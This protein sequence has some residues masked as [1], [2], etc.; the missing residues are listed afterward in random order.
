MVVEKRFL[1]PCLERTSV[2]VSTQWFGSDHLPRAA[3]FASE[4]SLSGYTSFISE[5]VHQAP[6]RAA[7]LDAFT[8]V[9]LKEPRSLIFCPGER[10]LTWSSACSMLGA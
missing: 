8:L 10:F 9:K 1:Q 7:F 4:V 6:F 2:S 3:V 5:E